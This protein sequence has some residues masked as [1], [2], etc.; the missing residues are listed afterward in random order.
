VTNASSLSRLI[1]FYSKLQSSVPEVQLTS[2]SSRKSEQ[3]AREG[4][5]LP[6]RDETVRNHMEADRLNSKARSEAMRT[7]ISPCTL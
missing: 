6:Q 7:M 5:P 3:E 2:V 4:S 1:K